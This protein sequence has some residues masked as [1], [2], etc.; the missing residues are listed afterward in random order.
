M[1][2]ALEAVKTEDIPALRREPI[3]CRKQLDETLLGIK[4][5]FLRWFVHHSLAANGHPVG[6]MPLAISAAQP[7]FHSEAVHKEVRPDPVEVCGGI[8]NVDLGL[9]CG[10]FQENLLY[11]VLSF[12]G[13][14]KPNREKPNK[15]YAF[16]QI[17]V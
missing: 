15:I 5:V 13:C 1:C 17:D 10:D 11:E 2:F 16:S 6:I 9:D 8:S 4:R 3:D 14:S 7:H 12:G